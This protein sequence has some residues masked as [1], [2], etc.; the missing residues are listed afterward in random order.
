MPFR[1]QQGIL[2]RG[3]ISHSRGGIPRSREA[4]RTAWRSF[5]SA[6]KPQPY[7]ASSKIY[8]GVVGFGLFT[9]GT[10][11]AYK[12][13]YD[14]IVSHP[15][16]LEAVEKLNQSR[17]FSGTDDDDGLIRVGGNE[18]SVVS[19]EPFKVQFRVSTTQGNAT[20]T[21]EA[22]QVDEGTW[23]LDSLLIDYPSSL[24]RYFFD[25]E[26]GSFFKGSMPAEE[27]SVS[28]VVSVAVE[29][30]YGSWWEILLQQWNDS[31]MYRKGLGLCAL[32]LPLGAWMYMQKLKPPMVCRRVLELIPENSFL[33]K[34]LGGPVEIT[35]THKGKIGKES[36]VF[37][38]DVKGLSQ[39][40]VVKFQVFRDNSRW[41]VTDAR[42]TATG[43][44]RAKK[45]NMDLD[46]YD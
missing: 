24:D 40:G 10:S 34:T 45:F 5:A 6:A 41:R 3:F 13:Y 1:P 38:V 21:V 46:A 33:K 8:F 22:H 27:L 30:T 15:A 2:L 28:D 12:Q 20:A 4:K 26:T 17:L 35:S 43:S 23:A 19:Y 37:T 42:F 44:A 36:G 32:A 31:S 9:F 16:I 18:I 39:G 7:L 14:P 25:G 29:N 11:Y